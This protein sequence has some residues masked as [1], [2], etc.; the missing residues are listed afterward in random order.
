MVLFSG[1]LGTSSVS[2]DAMEEE[3]TAELEDQVH[4]ADTAKGEASQHKAQS[5][6]GE[7]L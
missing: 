2:P 5:G 4:T 7:V 1:T 3:D 6:G